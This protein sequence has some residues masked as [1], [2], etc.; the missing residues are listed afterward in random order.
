MSPQNYQR[1]IVDSSW[2]PRQKEF[3]Y[4]FWT[5]INIFQLKKTEA[6]VLA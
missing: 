2:F 5:N 3:L 6:N 1:Q 4:I